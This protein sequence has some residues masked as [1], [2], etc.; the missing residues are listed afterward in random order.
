M[1]NK[2]VQIGLT[3]VII[4]GAIL[5][6]VVMERN[7]VTLQSVFF[8][9]ATVTFIGHWYWGLVAYIKYLGPTENLIEFFLDLAAVIALISTIFWIN[10]P[11]MWFFLNGLS[12][13][14]A[15]TKYIVSLKT[16]KL[17][18]ALVDY[19]KEKMRIHSAGVVG[20]LLGIP[21]ALYFNPVWLLGLLT[22]VIHSS[23]IIYLT[24]KKVYDFS[25]AEEK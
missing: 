14:L 15:V 7:M 25:A 2:S 16:R 12:F 21:G 9:L 20:I 23:L 19:I 22:L 1:D 11:P 3:N 18:P 8:W 10:I 17:S 24:L 5:W 6:L 13:S 4:G